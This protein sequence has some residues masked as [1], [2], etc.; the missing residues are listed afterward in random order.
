MSELLDNTRFRIERLKRMIRRLHDGEDPESLKEEFAEI[1]AEVGPG[2]ISTLET[3]LMDEGLPQSEV[4]RMCDVHAALF[5]DI[6][7]PASTGAEVPGHPLHTL[8]LENER[9]RGLV[10]EYRRLLD[11][12]PGAEGER[13]AGELV[14]RWHKLHGRLSL[15]TYHYQ[16]KELLIFP[17][18]E[19]AGLTGPPK[20][21]W[22]VHDEIRELLAAAAE[23]VDNAAELDGAA[24]TLARRTV[25][26]PMLDKIESMTEKEDRILVPMVSEHVSDTDWS[27]AAAEWRDLGPMLAEPAGVWLPVLTSAPQRPA[28]ASAPDEAIE[29]PSGRLTVRQLVALLDTLPADLTFV[30][31]DNRVA[32]FSEGSDRVFA[33]SRT[34]IGRRVEDCHPPKSIHIVERVVDDLRS[35]R[36]DVAEFW[37]QAEGRFI[38]IR[39]F[40]VRSPEGEYLGTLEVT[41]DVTGI[42][43]LEGERRLLDEAPPVEA[44]P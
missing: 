15:V 5:R 26:E 37:I 7:R 25:L 18:L 29:L 38:H 19:K 8:T 10:A 27:R 9:I 23:L 43:A 42:R 6:K 22:G 44:G 16:R 11:E 14:T 24:L 40:A 41:Q 36:R 4:Q 3:Q 20:V 30:D 35:G 31:A 32:Y 34:I 28:A 2:E 13:P 21:M 17:F 39:Y 33:R 1:L 12:L